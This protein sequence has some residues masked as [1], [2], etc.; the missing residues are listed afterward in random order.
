MNKNIVSFDITK[1]IMALLVVAIHTG[2]LLEVA[3]A[4]NFILVQGFAR[5]AVPFFFATSGY[6][7]FR[8]LDP[9][10]SFQGNKNRSI[11]WSYLKKLLQMYLAY[12]LLYLPLVIL[13]W[14]NGG[15]DLSSIL[16]LVRDF[17]FTGTWY[18]LWYFPALFFAVASIFWLKQK[19]NWK[20]IAMLTLGLYVFG[21]LGNLYSSWFTSIPLLDSLFSIYTA[22]FVTTRNGLFFGMAFVAMGA[23]LATHPLPNAKKT[24]QGLGISLVLLTLEIAFLVQMELM[25]DLASMYFFLLPTIYFLL[26]WL[27]RQNVTPFKG[28]L[29]LRRSSILIYGLHIWVIQVLLATSSFLSIPLSNVTLFGATVLLSLATSAILIWLSEK[30]PALKLLG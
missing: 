15:F 11:V 28:A 14:L 20:G 23:F 4:A 18:H 24:L 10:D 8:K 26:A 13:S 9:N 7:L 2:P 30:I 19:S 12:S 29:F 17:L 5:L 27:L 16:R 6:L 25:H 1:F 21:M 22:V 3:P